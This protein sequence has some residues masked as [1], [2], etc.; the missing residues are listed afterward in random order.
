MG[1]EKTNYFYKFCKKQLMM[2]DSDTTQK[3]Y[4]NY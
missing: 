2:N 3:S 1:E 4:I